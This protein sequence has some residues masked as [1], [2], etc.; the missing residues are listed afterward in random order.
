MKT[1][2]LLFA[3]MILLFAACNTGT[4]ENENPFLADYETP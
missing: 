3:T 1:K 2:T 4:T